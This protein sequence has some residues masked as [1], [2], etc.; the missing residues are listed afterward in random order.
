MKVNERKGEERRGRGE[1]QQNQAGLSAVR[2]GMVCL[3]GRGGGGR[4]GGE[5]GDGGRGVL[6]IPC[7]PFQTCALACTNRTKE[8]ADRI[9]EKRE[10]STTFC[11]FKWDRH[12]IIRRGGV[13]VG[14]GGG[15]GQGIISV[16][17]HQ[18]APA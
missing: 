12:T 2:W 8:G 7:L 13:A 4:G 9:G 16:T 14:V 11:A 17:D 10:C 15:G 3:W 1:E 18:Q 6:N 5:G